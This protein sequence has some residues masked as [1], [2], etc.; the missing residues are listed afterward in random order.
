MLKALF[1][2]FGS[3]SLVKEACLSHVFV[4]FVSML[5]IN[6][7]DRLENCRS[8][9]RFAEFSRVEIKNGCGCQGR[10]RDRR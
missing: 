5:L 1:K 8:G 4:S 3:F 9:T 6:S 10:H 2:S 7:A